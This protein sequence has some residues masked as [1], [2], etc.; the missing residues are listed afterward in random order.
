MPPLQALEHIIQKQPIVATHVGI[1]PATHWSQTIATYEQEAHTYVR[2]LQVQHYIDQLRASILAQET[3]IG[4][5]VA[6]FGYGKTSTAID[7]WYHCHQANILA[8]PPFSCHSISEMGAAIASALSLALADQQAIVQQITDAYQEYLISSATHL[9]QQDVSQYGIPF[10]IALQSIEDKIQ[11]GY[12]HLEAG[13]INLLPFL[14][15]ATTLV[16]EAGYAGWLLLVDEFQQF[17]GNL[18]KVVITN[19][20]TLIWGLKTRPAMPFGFMMT[21]DP[22]TERNL[23]EQAGD[24]LHRIKEHG[25]FLNFANVYD[26]EFPRLLWQQYTTQFQID[27]AEHRVVERT[28]LE[29][30]GQICERPDLSNGPRTLIDAF[31][32]LATVYQER[33]KPYTPL[34]LIADFLSGALKFDG[35]H[36][37]LASLVNELSGYDYI[38]RI[39]ERLTAIR[40]IAA[41]PRG[42]PREIA[43]Q[44]G[45]VDAYDHLATELRGEILTELPE[46]MALIDLQRVGKPQNKLKI[47]LKKY[48]LQITETELAMERAV[49]LFG[50]LIV[51]TLF[52]PFQHILAGWRSQEQTFQLLETGS[53]FQIYEGTFFDEFP[54]RRIGVQL[55]QSLTQAVALDNVD[56]NLIFELSATNDTITYREKQKAII[57]SVALYQSFGQRLPRNLQWIEDYLRPVQITPSVLLSLIAYINVQAPTIPDISDTERLKITTTLDRLQEYFL[58]NILQITPNGQLPIQILGVGGQGLKELLFQIWQQTYP[59]Y[60]TL[61]TSVHW[62]NSLQVYNH[63]LASLTLSQKRGR[64]ALSTS[65]KEIANRFSMQKHA[66]FK[67]KAKQY[68]G[69]LVIENWQGQEGRLSFQ[70]HVGEKALLQFIT[71]WEEMDEDE[72]AAQMHQMG[73]LPQ[74]VTYLR[75]FLETRGYIQ[76]VPDRKKYTLTTTIAPTELSILGTRLLSEIKTWQSISTETAA[77]NYCQGK[78]ELLLAQLTEHEPDYATIQ[79]Q[80]TQLQQ[81]LSEIEEKI[82]VHIQTALVEMRQQLYE[83]LEVLTMTLPL[84]DTGLQLDAHINGAQRVLMKKYRV[85]KKQTVGLLTDVDKVLGEVSAGKTA[86]QLIEPYTKI[87][88]HFGQQQTSNKKM[89]ELNVVHHSW[90]A[91][92]AK[93]KRLRIYLG[94]IDFVDTLLLENLLQSEIEAIASALATQ[95]IDFYGKTLADISPKIDGI[96][97]EIELAIRVRDNQDK[98]HPEKLEVADRVDALG[99][100]KNY[101]ESLFDN[102]LGDGVLLQD[103]VRYQD[104][105]TMEN[106]LEVSEKRNVIIYLKAKRIES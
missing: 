6:P 93:I 2:P 78:I 7:I 76:Y 15:K 71:Q 65:K 75:S 23:S 62:E 83:Q 90:V 35:D 42:C 4:C 39:P 45:V 36:N 80:L 50:E 24:I 55:C 64:E 72:M 37:L 68:D 82:M 1:F 58:I 98:N 30:L 22:N 103:L 102:L 60:Q 92:L 16:Q 12:L 56:I 99:P 66:G 95:N 41:F 5:L 73:Y 100:D 33:E 52:P 8:I 87:S 88:S 54:L 26:R 69:L 9:A 21:M 38:R 47:I 18:N 67:S 96:A 40:L 28:T 86:K 77:L 48:W 29:S 17:L 94:T 46:G 81:Q 70:Q 61:V 32:R 74:E 79:A 34:D 85:A 3:P 14:E 63:V 49:A 53:C 20:R 25:L 11:Q 59:H 13:A 19:F 91:F 27:E 106:L 104:F 51:P 43:Q 57:I 89:E 31:Q 44:F 97:H 101:D 105:S 10:E 84:S